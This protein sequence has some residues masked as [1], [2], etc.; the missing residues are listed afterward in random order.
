MRAP[1]TTHILDT[2]TGKPAA[3]VAVVLS[4][5]VDSGWQVIT[6]GE[7]NADGRVEQ[8]QDSFS[9]ADG[10]YKL[11]FAVAD[12]FSAQH[13]ASFYPEVTLTF[14]VDGAQPHYH[15]PLLLSAYGFT[16]YRGS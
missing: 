14:N 7:T 5:Q 6:R 16:T 11:E 4:Q 2:Q 10:I 1:I 15:V 3:E 12:Y 13:I 8:W 9:L